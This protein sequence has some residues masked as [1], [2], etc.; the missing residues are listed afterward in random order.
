MKKISCLLIF[1]AALSLLAM[2]S[3]KEETLNLT[4]PDSAS[5]K[6][7]TRAEIDG[8]NGKTMKL[9]S[10]SES[11]LVMELNVG[12]YAKKAVSIE[13]NEYFAIS[14]PEAH[15]MLKAGM[16]DLPEYAYSVVIPPTTACNVRVV[17]AEY[18]DISLPVAPSKGS[19]I[20]PN[21]PYT[22]AEAYE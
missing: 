2:V 8:L 10:S 22:F 5:W 16:P 20:S 9:L 12:N 6:A 14:A 1:A 3:C 19:I 18:E 15:S 7:Q 21:E 11:A 4:P 17:N 13:G